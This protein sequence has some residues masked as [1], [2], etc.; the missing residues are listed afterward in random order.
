ME[1]FKAPEL[2]DTVLLQNYP[3]TILV[4]DE[5]CKEGLPEHM[6]KDSIIKSLSFKLPTFS[7][8]G[9]KNK[10]GGLMSRLTSK[11]LKST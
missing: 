7:A 3:Q 1:I 11:E 10:G 5:V 2:T 4:I 6:D 9:D 8:D